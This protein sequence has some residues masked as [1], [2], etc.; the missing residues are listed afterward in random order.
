MR[1]IYWNKIKENVSNNNP[2]LTFN[3]PVILSSIRNSISKELNLPKSFWDI[4][5]D[6][7]WDFFPCLNNHM[8]LIVGFNENNNSICYNDPATDLFGD[9]KCGTYAWM[10]KNKFL[11]KVTKAYMAIIGNGKEDIFCEN[12]L[13]LPKNWSQGTQLNVEMNSFDAL[14][15]NPPFGSRIQVRGDK[16]LSQYDLGYHWKRK[17]GILQRTDKLYKKQSPPNIIH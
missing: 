12:N 7:L 17:K 6:I 16:L 15:T 4:L 5:P 10:D 3:D 2:V 8:I 14:F 1:N 9:P 11:V 13:D